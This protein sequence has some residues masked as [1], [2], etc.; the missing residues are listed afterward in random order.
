MQA[1]SGT[2]V[3]ALEPAESEHWDTF[4]NTIFLWGKFLRKLN[5]RAQVE[6]VRSTEN[7]LDV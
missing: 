7:D 6:N 1:V 5:D 2:F 4:F 3:C